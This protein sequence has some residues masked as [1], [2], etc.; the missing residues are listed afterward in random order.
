MYQ[1]LYRK[2]RSKTFDELVGQNHI[3]TALKNQIANNEISHAYLFSGTRGTGKTS[4]AKIFA[5]A[6]NCLCSENGNPCNH[7]E[8]CLSILD[9]RVMDVIEMDAASNNSV[10]DIRELK[11]KVVYPPQNLKYKVY[12][13]DEVHMLSK[14]AFNALLKVLE[15]PPKHLIFILATTE[16]EK[17]PQTILSRT[18]RFN[19]KRIN[20]EIII[21]NLK[22]I[23]A[24]E[25]K[26]CDE[27]VFSLIS[28]NSDGA[29]RDALSLLDQCL[30]FTDKH[31][32]YNLA[33]EILGITSDDILFKIS[34]ALIDRNLEN[35][36]SS[37]QEIYSKGKDISILI[38]DLISHF[39]NLMIVKTIKN[40]SELLYTTRLDD[41]IKEACMLSVDRIIDILKIL[42]ETLLNVKYANDKRIIFEMS[43]IKITMLKDT[44][45]LEERI[46]ALEDIINSGNFKNV[47]ETS[48]V[49]NNLKSIDND[50]K[51]EA[52]SKKLSQ[53]V[54]PTTVVDELK[55]DEK[56]E[57][58][59]DIINDGNL[60]LE[61]IKSDWNNILIE[62]KNRKRLNI[63]I[64]L[65]FAKL[66]NFNQNTLLIEF[67]ESNKFNYESL[68]NKDN[69]NFIEDFLSKYYND[70]ISVKI[71]L[72]DNKEIKLAVKSAE[73]LFGSKNIEII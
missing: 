40:T 37:L 5:R 65:S 48:P 8:N 39:R 58:K 10:D 30:S 34:R 41:Y 54:F 52:P 19:F 20:P 29:M 18:Q 56:K 42:N 47:S 61:K 31:I 64:Q 69:I 49:K 55:D 63:P 45:S 68:S 23:T 25:N 62:I 4:A 46:K 60:T 16:P 7:C 33:T 35:A 72:T 22:N 59:S 6:V 50:T 17:I 3:T 12:I 38:S 1:A 66:V 15:E 36:I 13:I 70:K 14:S 44:V 27:D 28:N 26:S 43:I 32:S 2:Y 57:E 51:I 53:E 11:E 67:D 24:L 21:E 9:D 71:V 73:D